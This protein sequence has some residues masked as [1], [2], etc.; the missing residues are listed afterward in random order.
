MHAMNREILF[1]GKCL[2][3]REWVIGAYIPYLTGNPVILELD[4][5][6]ANI[7]DP[8]TVGQFTG[9]SDSIGRK[10]FEDDVVSVNL[11]MGGSTE[12]TCIFKE[13]SFELRSIVEGCREV[14]DLRSIV[15][16]GFDYKVVGNL[17]DLVQ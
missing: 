4:P 15:N 8:S 2:D 17:H 12:Y 1:R 14:C 5:T 6:R 11:L 7:V 9:I 13:G 3:T 10:I 16:C